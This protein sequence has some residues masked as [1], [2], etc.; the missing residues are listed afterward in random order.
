MTEQTARSYEESCALLDGIVG[1]CVREPA[2][3]AAVLADPAA[4]LAAYRLSQHELDDFLALRAG[5]A[6][7]ARAVWRLVRA[8][9]NRDAAV[10]K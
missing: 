5:H 1:R 3:G 7:E 10:A 8:R 4:A 6:E 2:F 9:L